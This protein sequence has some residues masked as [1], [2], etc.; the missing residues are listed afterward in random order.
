M[1]ADD[2]DLVAGCLRG[3]RG[4]AEALIERY[5]RPVF[6][7]ARRMVAQ[8]EDARDVAQNV[9]LKAF[10][11]LATFDARYPFRGW[12]G[13]IAVNESLDWLAARR[14][15]EPLDEEWPDAGSGTGT[16]GIDLARAVDRALARL[17]P[18]Y[19]SVVVLFYF[20]DLSYREIGRLLELPEKTVKSRLF[21]SR[22]QLRGMLAG[23]DRV[24]S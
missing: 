17:E 7:I 3:D 20:L 16:D 9:F 19:R 12:I 21:T 4:A 6:N 15:G 13:R 14:P 11:H 23:H 8:P 1:E 18:H 24:E 10:Q 2:R 5:Q 22:Q